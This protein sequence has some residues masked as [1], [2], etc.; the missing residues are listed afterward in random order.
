MAN[1]DNC[2]DALSME[3]PNELKGLVSN[4]ELDIPRLV[5]CLLEKTIINFTKTL[6]NWG[7]V[8]KKN[9]I[10]KEQKIRKIIYTA[11]NL[12]LSLISIAPVEV[13]ESIRKIDKIAT[14]IVAKVSLIKGKGYLSFAIEKGTKKNHNTW[15]VPLYKGKEGLIIN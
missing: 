15:I 6:G 3:L 1:E 13:S 14:R 4:L 2:Y 11:A 5:A 10:L 7:C 12:F 8:K 9:K